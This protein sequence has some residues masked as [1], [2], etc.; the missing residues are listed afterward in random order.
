MRKKLL[1]FV[2]VLMML[3]LVACTSEPA[4]TP[5]TPE[6]PGEE[7]P[8]TPVV[9]E[10]E[11]E[12]VYRFADSSDV[13][14]LNPHNQVSVLI[15]DI[16]AFTDSKLYRKV[17][18][19]DG[20]GWDFVGDIAEGR[21]YLPDPDNGYVWHIP[22]RKDAVWANGE[23][24]NAHTFEYSFK[25]LLDPNL[26][27]SL[28]SFLYDYFITIDMAYEY[29]AQNEEGMDPVAWEDVGIKAVDDYT[30]EIRTD[31]LYTDELVM[32]HFMLRSMFPVY[33]PYY[34]AGMNES[35]TATTYGA[36]LEQYMGCGPYFFDS[37]I[38]D[39]SRTYTKNE[40][41]WMAD[42]FKFDKIDV[43]IVPDANA[44]TQMFENG[45]IDVMGVSTA[46]LEKYRDDPRLFKYSSIYCVHIDINSL[47]TENP[48]LQTLNFRKALNM[49]IKREPLA[50]MLDFIPSAYYISHQAGAPGRNMAYR[51]TPEAQAWLPE[52]YG[53]D[54]VKAKEYYDAALKE[55]GQDSATVEIMINDN[56]EDFKMIAEYLQAE[57][58]KVFGED[59]FKLE[60]RFVPSANYD[61]I[62]D[63][64][65]DPNSFELACDGWGSTLA[66]IYPYA[67]FQWFIDSYE[68]RPNSYTT[69]RFE[70]A[71]AELNTEEMRTNPELMIK[72]TAELEQIFW[73][74][75]IN[76]PLF[77]QYSYTMYQDWFEPGCPEY[78]AGFGFGNMFG[79]IVE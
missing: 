36:T 39:A 54:P 9:E 20:T 69:D 51:D 16:Q 27:N 68:S 11:I 19:N 43:R 79:R 71:Y 72:K 52:N 41:H 78:I 46:A 60:I 50:E 37:W 48:I 66:R 24:I 65:A 40:D 57:L 26:V 32:E 58:P 42:Y 62:K 56:D 3:A 53:F 74:D 44:R 35:R 45:E 14:S 21:P 76:V 70:Q 38:P 28:A 77:Q 15:G 49:G 59:K 4:A 73:E 10:P 22:I 31:Q 1:F 25:M 55:I 23:P 30:L 17:P 67:A 6:T 18:I 33:E 8:E 34:E 61:A 47:N 29:F 75:V 7:V 5:P 2:A 13:T 63:W 12:Q 64:K